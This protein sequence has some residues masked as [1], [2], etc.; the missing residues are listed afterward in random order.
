LAQIFADIGIVK[1]A[2]VIEVTPTQLK[3]AV[4]G[5][6]EQK[7]LSL[8]DSAKDSSLFIDEAYLMD[9]GSSYGQAMLNAFV[10]LFDPSPHFRPMIIMAGYDYVPLYF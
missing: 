3:G 7:I 9:D 2:D 6:A 1:K 4:V 8:F 5:E 10:S